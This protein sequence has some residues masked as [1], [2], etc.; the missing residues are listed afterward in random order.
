M[1]RS[2]WSALCVVSFMLG[3][4]NVSEEYGDDTDY[5]DGYRKATT[6]SKVMADKVW[7]FMPAPGQFIN[8]GY[9][10]ATMQAACSYAEERFT[11]SAYVSLGGWGG[12]IV[13]G[14]DHSVPNREGYDL[15]IRGNTIENSSEPGVVWVMQDSNG[16]G[17]P[18]DTWY[19]LAGS[20]YGTTK[21]RA[22]YSVTYYRPAGDC[23]SVAWRDADG[24]EG[25][26]DYMP[27][28]HTQASYYPAWVTTDS[29]R[30]SGVLLEANNV[31]LESGQWSNRPYE[32]GYADNMSPIDYRMGGYN[33]FDIDKAVKADG[34]AAALKY[35][36]FVKVQTATNAKSGHLGENST[37]VCSFEDL[38]LAK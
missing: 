15:R 12:Y 28:D 37:E 10:A 13:V 24:I 34:S 26:I 6:A 25:E 36:D 35:I 19:E 23:M 5:G 1:R 16:N 31:L 3:A 21:R 7:E 30:L 20:A 27:A 4:C 9:H 11:V 18:D 2:L 17:A 14:F 8:E 38:H 29:Y 33:S 32:W 22:D